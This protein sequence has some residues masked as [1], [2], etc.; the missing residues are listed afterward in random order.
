MRRVGY[1]AV[2][3]L[4]AVSTAI[5]RGFGK[6]EPALPQPALGMP[7]G[8]SVVAGSYTEP[9]RQAI[10][11][12][13]GSINTARGSEP[14]S[15]PSNGEPPGAASLSDGKEVIGLPFPTSASVESG[16]MN[17]SKPGQDACSETHGLLA[18]MAQ[19]PRDP[20]WA[21]GTEAKLRELIL[22]TE[23]GKFV[24]RTV[25]C[26]TSLC[27]VEVVSQ[28]AP[29]PGDIPRDNPLNG[30][31]SLADIGIFGHERNAQGEP[32]TVSV[33]PFQRR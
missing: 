2:F 31:L 12:T 30:E 29:F 7:A 11:A 25:E 16:C 9:P 5:L 33:V 3:A 10:R 27:V 8:R 4:I 24:P 32:V 22:A 23:S 6:H 21:P 13:S 18:R 15:L 1:L 20:V 17:L 26:R 14:S 19:E 28:N